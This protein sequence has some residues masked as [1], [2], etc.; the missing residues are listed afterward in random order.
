MHTAFALDCKS[1]VQC[2]ACALQDAEGDGVCSDGDF[3]RLHSLSN[4]KLI[5]SVVMCS[6]FRDGRW[7]VQFSNG[8]FGAILPERI[9]KVIPIGGSSEASSVVDEQAIAALFSPDK[10]AADEVSPPLLPWDK[11]LICP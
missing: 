2:N 7:S 3:G 1:S 6:D 10:E 8:S 5:G 4:E 9:R 11:E